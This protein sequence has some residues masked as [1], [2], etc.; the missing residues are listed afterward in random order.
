MHHCTSGR[1]EVQ[2]QESGHLQDT[3]PPG[4]GMWSRARPCTEASVERV[5]GPTLCASVP[6]PIPT[7]F[8]QGGGLCPG[9]QFPLYQPQ[10][11]PRELRNLGVCQSGLGNRVPA[12]Q[13]RRLTV[14]SC[15]HQPHPWCMPCVSVTLCRN[16]GLKSVGG[17]WKSPPFCRR[18]AE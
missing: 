1:L 10:C 12:S 4:H 6:H 16:L 5:S 8:Q 14:Q 18:R 13:P 11:Q 2:G 15:L 17:P 9:Q 7:R 3:I